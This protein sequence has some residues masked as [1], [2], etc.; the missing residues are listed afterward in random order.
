MMVVDMD[1]KGAREMRSAGT[2]GVLQK[3]ARLYEF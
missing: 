3:T 1:G 2:R